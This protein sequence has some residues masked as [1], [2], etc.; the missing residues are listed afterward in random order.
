MNILL[1]GGTGFI[2]R[3]L[4]KKLNKSNKHDLTCLVLKQ[5]NAS[6]IPENIKTIVGDVTKLE[7]L[8][9]ALE[10]MDAVINLA[11]PNTQ[12][13][14][15]NQKVIVEGSKNLL[16]ATHKNRVKK[17]ITFSSAA[18]YRKNLDNYGKAKKEADEI[19]LKSNQEI[20]IL[21]PTMVCGRGGYAFE[22]V[23]SSLRIPFFAFVVGNGKY[24]VQ[25]AFLSDVVRSIE[26]AID[27]E[28][29]K[30]VMFDIAGPKKIKYNEFVKKILSVKK[31]K[32]IIIHIP[33]W[34]IFSL[35]KFT[36]IFI[37]NPPFNKTTIK[38]MVEEID[39]DVE[40]TQKELKIEFT[41]YDEGLKE[42][43][44]S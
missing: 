35:I 18:G 1:T 7:D 33:L 4:L 19:L 32:K 34:I 6:K 25:P 13:I 37:K 15:T 5:E 9:K 44:N 16:K 36:K 27:Y 17:I 42:I 11:V 38:R 26:R 29:G 10:N 31:S 28:T 12:N 21:K 43:F 20:I 3:E 24:K 40:K 2:G 41:S 39:M 30:P 22:K 8:E 23:V 14:E